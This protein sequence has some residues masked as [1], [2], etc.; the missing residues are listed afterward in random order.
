MSGSPP[1]DDERLE[2]GEGSF[3]STVWRNSF[4][5]VEEPLEIDWPQ[6]L[7]RVQNYAE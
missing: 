1:G 4:N 5:V 7:L 3:G 6:Q 2:G